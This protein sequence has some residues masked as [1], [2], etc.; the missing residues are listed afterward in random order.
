MKKT[1]KDC[2]HGVLDLSET[3]TNIAIKRSCLQ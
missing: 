3:G 1:E 2:V